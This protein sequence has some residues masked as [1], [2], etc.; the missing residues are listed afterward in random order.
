MKKYQHVFVGIPELAL[1]SAKLMQSFPR[2]AA[3]ILPLLEEVQHELFE[4]LVQ[5]WSKVTR[6][7]SVGLMTLEVRTSM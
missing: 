3:V 1:N 5:Q 2:E 6:Y 7:G 4:P